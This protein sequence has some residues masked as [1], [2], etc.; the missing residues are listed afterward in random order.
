MQVD[1]LGHAGHL[2]G[3]DDE[4]VG[5]RAA[6]RAHRDHDGHDAVAD[7]EGSALADL[8]DHAGGVGAGDVG[9]GRVRRCPG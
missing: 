2:R 3:R 4:L 6:V 1:A 7:G 8:A 9:T 5:V